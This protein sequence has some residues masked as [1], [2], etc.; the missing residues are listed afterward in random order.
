MVALSRSTPLEDA[1]SGM[2]AILYPVSLAIALL[3][4]PGSM[5]ENESA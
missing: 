1:G 2:Q 5:R 4:F 3:S